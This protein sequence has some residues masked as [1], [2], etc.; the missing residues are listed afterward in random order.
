MDGGGEAMASLTPTADH[1]VR[2]AISG[3]DTGERRRGD[4]RQGK[5]MISFPVFRGN[6][7][8]FRG[9]LLGRRQAKVREVER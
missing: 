6:E 4:A 1:W 3:E 2:N 7:R 5:A 9:T 8:E